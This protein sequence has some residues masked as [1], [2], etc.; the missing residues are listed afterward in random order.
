MVAEGRTNVEIAA[1]LH[2]SRQAVNYHVGRLMRALGAANRTALVAR[3]Y[4][5]GLLATG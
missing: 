2:L 5:R 1:A 4:Q 3:A